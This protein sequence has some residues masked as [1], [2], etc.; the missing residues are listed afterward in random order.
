MDEKLTTYNKIWNKDGYKTWGNK[1]NQDCAS[2]FDLYFHTE[3]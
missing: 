2:V 1:N 3:V